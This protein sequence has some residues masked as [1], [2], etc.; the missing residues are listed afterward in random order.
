[1]K[2]SYQTPMLRVTPYGAAR[3]VTGSCHYIEFGERRILFDCGMHQG[4]RELEKLNL[5][6]FRFEVSKLDC[7]ILSH[8]HIDHSGLLP[9]LVKA[10]YA[11]PIYTTPASI[12]L[13]EILLSDSAHLHELEAAGKNRRLERA[14]RPLIKPLYTVEDAA[15]VG[16]LMRPV[17]YQTEFRPVPGCVVRFEDAGHILG[18][19]ITALNFDLGS[20][21]HR[22]VMSGDIG[23]FNMP[24]LRD[25]TLL[26]EADTLVMEST[27]GDRD[28]RDRPATVEELAG[29]LVEAKQRGGAV[30]IPAFAVGRT[31]E[32]L[33]QLFQ[34]HLQK[35]LPI[36]DVFIDSPMAQRTTLLYRQSNALLDEESKALFRKCEPCLDLVT[37]CET[38]EDSMRL[39]QRRGPHII[40]SASGMCTGGRVLHHLRHNLWKPEATIIFVGFQAYGSL[41]RQIVDGAKSVRI[42]G[43]PVAVRARVHT[44]GGFS[45]HAGR[46]D[47]LR[48]H[49]A[50][51]GGRMRTILVHG[52]PKP[53]DSLAE[54]IAQRRG[55]RPVCPVRGQTISCA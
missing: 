31:Q 5:G 36:T 26:S 27:Y 17:P 2:P 49:D 21:R 9:K 40:I 7:V 13:T 41:G 38:K 42:F 44:L 14:G 16:P 23:P 51:K 30:I 39:N 19:S 25:P 28:H 55:E 18:S 3:E 35:R 34:L 4:G 12:N 37:F 1:M 24:L 45:A 10:G 20:E 6:P 8:A 32:L 54:A 11:G 48:W 47:L 52:E 15:R 43:E 50:F 22:L 29:V 46:S 33:Y 53:M